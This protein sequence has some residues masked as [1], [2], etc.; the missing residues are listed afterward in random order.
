MSTSEPFEPT[1]LKKIGGP[2][3]K[4]AIFIQVID[5]NNARVSI[6]FRDGDELDQTAP[7]QDA[8]F[9]HEPRKV[10]IKVSGTKYKLTPDEVIKLFTKP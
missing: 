1:L 6:V 8:T 4:K 9:I 10:W 2:N 5:E 7:V 3:W